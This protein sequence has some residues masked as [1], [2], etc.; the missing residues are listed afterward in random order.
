MTDTELFHRSRIPFA[1]INNKL[2]FTM[3]DKRGHKEW[4]SETYKISNEDYEDTIRGYMKDG[5]VF[6]YKTSKFIPVDLKEIGIDTLKHIQ[7]LS[8]VYM[9]VYNPECFNGMHV[10]EPGAKWE[11]LKNLGNIQDILSQRFRSYGVA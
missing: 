6:F 4:L 9:N 8:M 1:I 3:Y 2:V 11:P 10:G 5:Q 7:I